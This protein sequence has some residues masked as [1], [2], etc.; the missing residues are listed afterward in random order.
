MADEKKTPNPYID[1]RREWMERYGDYIKAKKVWQGIAFFSIAVAGVAIVGALSLAKKSEFV[2]YVV[3]L[4]KLGR[5]NGTSFVDPNIEH[6]AKY[7]RSALASWVQD[8]RSVYTDGQAQR[9]NV[10]RAF[11]AVNQGDP[12]FLVL[13]G[14]SKENWKRASNEVVSVE[15]VGEPLA[16]TSKTWQVEWIESVTARSGKVLRSEVWR[17]NFELYFSTPKSQK[18]LLNNPL[19]MYIKTFN[20]SKQRTIPS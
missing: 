18:T 8:T 5:V 9:L 15:I 3:E 19:G 12:A 1:G 4:D 6:D 16:I 10:E 14:F 7:I 20:W 11:A 17:G 2:P 13:S